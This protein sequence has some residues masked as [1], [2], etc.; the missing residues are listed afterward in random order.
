MVYVWRGGQ[1]ARVGVRDLGRVRVD[2]GAW[3]TSGRGDERE[4]RSV[5]A[6][7]RG[8][9]DRRDRAPMRELIPQY[10]GT[11]FDASTASGGVKQRARRAEGRGGRD[12]KGEDERNGWGSRIRRE[13][14]RLRDRMC[15]RRCVEGKKKSRPMASKLEEFATRQAGPIA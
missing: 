10:L 14:A 1:W 5:I 8:G 15:S 9:L 6:C 2:F 7:Q 11:T 3:R 13:G 12:G 4:G